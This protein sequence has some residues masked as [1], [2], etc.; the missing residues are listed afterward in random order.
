MMMTTKT[1]G[2][3]ETEMADEMETEMD[4][5]MGMEI[6]IE[7]TE[8]L[9]M[10]PELTML[11]TKMVPEEE[12]R[13][14]KFSGGLPDNIQGNIM[15]ITRFGMTLE[16]IEE[17]INQRVVEALAAYDANSVAKLVVESQSQNRDDD[18]NE[19]VRGNGNR[20]GR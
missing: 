18:D 15:T 8:V 9:C 6:L 16:A 3:M 2:E 14:K 17:L 7:M 4:E 10:S 5:A 13:V 20:N 19:N 1:L 11:C 12:D